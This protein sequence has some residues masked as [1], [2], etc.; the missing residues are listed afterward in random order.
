MEWFQKGIADPPHA[1]MSMTYMATFVVILLLFGGL[2][3]AWEA[4]NGLLPEIVATMDQPV[5]ELSPR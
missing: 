4:T 2:F 3:L 5:S 1:N